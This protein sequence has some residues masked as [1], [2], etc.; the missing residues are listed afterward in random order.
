MCPDK[1][2]VLDLHEA[3]VQGSIAIDANPK[4]LTT[5]EDRVQYLIDRL[6][7]KDF[8]RAELYRLWFKDFFKETQFIR[9]QKLYPVPDVGFTYIPKE[10]SLDLA[11]YQKTPDFRLKYRYTISQ[12]IWDQLDTLNKAAL[13]V[14]ELIYRE[15]SLP[16]NHHQ[17]S[18]SARFFNGWLNSTVFAEVVPQDY[19]IALQSLRFTSASY[20]NFKITLGMKGLHNQWITAPLKFYDNGNLMSA[21]T[22]KF[23]L[24][25][26]QRFQSFERCFI[27]PDHHSTTV[28]FK[29]DGS[30][31]RLDA[32]FSRAFPCDFHEIEGVR[33]SFFADGSS[34]GFGFAREDII[35]LKD[36]TISLEE[37]SRVGLNVSA[38]GK[39]E[40][41][42]LERPPCWD[43]NHIALHPFG[44][45]VKIHVKDLTKDRLPACFQ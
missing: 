26:L 15:A 21:M 3:E 1:S 36:V 34:Y 43:R 25:A 45:A 32:V 17:T 12:D 23:S 11:V 10:C 40:T 19:L 6:E 41:I 13:I 4:S 9:G 24:Q 30:I 33:L 20:K 5:V 39:V 44:R 37:E 14:H 7:E 38:A 2:V 35:I 22:T 27:N 18:E 16:E 29:E 31:D 28:T 42:E 8:Y